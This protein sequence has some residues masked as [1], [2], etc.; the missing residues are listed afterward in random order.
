MRVN[1][2]QRM[3]GD[4]RFSRIASV[5]GWQTRE[6]FGVCLYLWQESQDRLQVSGTKRQIIRW[7][8]LQLDPAEV[9]DKWFRAMCEENLLKR[10]RGSKQFII[11]GNEDR[12][13]ELK[14]WMSDRKITRSVTGSL[15]TEN[16]T[17]QGCEPKTLQNTEKTEEKPSGL[18]L[19]L[20][21]MSQSKDK[22]RESGDFLGDQEDKTVPEPEASASGTPPETESQTPATTEAEKP[23]NKIPWKW[24]KLEAPGD[25]TLANL[26][27]EYANSVIPNNRYKPDGFTVA[28]T[29][30]RVN[31]DLNFDQIRQLL[32]W[33]AQD[34][35][36]KDK[37]LSPEALL[38][39]SK[40][41][42]GLSKLHQLLMQL[43]NRKKTKDQLLQEDLERQVREGGNEPN[44][45]DMGPPG[46]QMN[47]TPER[48][49]FS[50]T[51]LEPI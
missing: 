45:F 23:K 50:Q 48:L 20:G 8:N 14:K 36:W 2:E 5:M 47:D 1:V 21:T 12:I 16:R 37:A 6:Q 46:P 4:R 38:K 33:I 18:S 11:A 35:F 41:D 29:K 49:D 30:M 34:D 39:P 51:T 9:Q 25:R 28:I 24:R 22:E 7:A 13:A 26:W 17:S 19:S 40:A 43:K 42:P 15:A 27:L 31:Y 32:D 44:P 3:F 10:K